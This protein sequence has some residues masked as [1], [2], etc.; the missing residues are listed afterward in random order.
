MERE[1]ESAGKDRTMIFQFWRHETY[2][3]KMATDGGYSRKKKSTEKIQK[4]K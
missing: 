3:C 4:M 2:Y 1:R